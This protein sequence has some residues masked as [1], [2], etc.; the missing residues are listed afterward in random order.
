M[1][2]N[3]KIALMAKIALHKKQNC[4]K[5]ARDYYRWDYIYKKN[6]RMRLFVFAGCV[7]ALI[8]KYLYVAAVLQTPMLSLNHWSEFINSS[9]FILAVVAGY[10]ILGSVIHFAE[11]SRFARA[12]EKLQ[13]MTNMLTRMP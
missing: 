13:E 4:D 7:I 1:R 9:I 5:M 12:E 10:T 2:E 3:D 6:S 8:F 11:Y